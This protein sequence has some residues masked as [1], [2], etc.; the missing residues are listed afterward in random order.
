MPP[1]SAFTHC[2]RERVQSIIHDASV[3]CHGRDSARTTSRIGIRRIRCGSPAVRKLRR[4]RATRALTPQRS[5]PAGL[6]LY[7]TERASP[8]RSPAPLTHCFKDNQGKAQQYAHRCECN[9]NPRNHRHEGSRKPLSGSVRASVY[10]PLIAATK[11]A[12]SML[13]CRHKELILWF[14]FCTRQHIVFACHPD[15]ERR[16]QKNT[17][18]Q[19]GNE[20]AYDNDGEGA[21]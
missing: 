21:L 6:R 20:P 8:P 10:H 13:A 9:T 18:D 12:V 16:Q 5:S 17:H 2:W 1:P 3:R 7:K 11:S 19:I 15:I 14:R 4:F